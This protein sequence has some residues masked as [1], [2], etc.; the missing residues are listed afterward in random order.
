MFFLLA[1]TVH[2]NR[3]KPFDGSHLYWLILDHIL[4][5]FYDVDIF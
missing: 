5:F 2:L 3:S 1:F 4:L